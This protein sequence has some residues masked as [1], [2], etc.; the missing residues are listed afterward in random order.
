MLSSEFEDASPSVSP[1]E[2]YEEDCNVIII[3][4]MAIVNQIVK[5]KD[6]LTCLV[7]SFFVLDSF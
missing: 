2:F 4:G 6:M 7:R 1:D 5:D 3:D